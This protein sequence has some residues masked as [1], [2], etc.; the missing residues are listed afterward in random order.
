MDGAGVLERAVD[1]VRRVG[2]VE[3]VLLVVTKG[4]GERAARA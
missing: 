3:Q 4:G 2:L 1:G